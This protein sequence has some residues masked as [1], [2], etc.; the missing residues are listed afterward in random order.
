MK[1]KL[2]LVGIAHFLSQGLQAQQTTEPKLVVKENTQIKE[3][4]KNKNSLPELFEQKLRDSK[5]GTIIA[6][7]SHESTTNANSHGKS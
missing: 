5:D 2:A 7:P 6:S 4:Q 1:L 3:A